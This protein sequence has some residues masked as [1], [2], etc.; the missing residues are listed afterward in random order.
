VSAFS[1]RPSL[2]WLPLA[3]V[4]FWFIPGPRLSAVGSEAEGG[5]GGDDE[6]KECSRPA[7][8][9]VQSPHVLP[10]GQLC[11]CCVEGHGVRQERRVIT[12][13]AAKQALGTRKSVSGAQLRRETIRV[14]Q[15]LTFVDYSRSSSH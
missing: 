13:R 5:E 10:A 14:L 6:P 2:P 11:R 12:D 1:S 8:I 7:V 4:W 9:S 3:C 15:L